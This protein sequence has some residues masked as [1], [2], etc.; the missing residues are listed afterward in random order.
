VIKERAEIWFSAANELL[1]GFGCQA[2]FVAFDPASGLFEQRDNVILNMIGVS[3]LNVRIRR[4]QQGYL[5][6]FLKAM[7]NSGCN[8]FTDVVGQ[9]GASSLC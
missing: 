9:H 2:H 5:F 6:S 7:V 3:Y 4:C 1:Y 8:L